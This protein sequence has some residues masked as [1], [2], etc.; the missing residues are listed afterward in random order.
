MSF[1]IVVPEYRVNGVEGRRQLQAVVRVRQQDGFMSKDF[2]VGIYNRN[3]TLCSLYSGKYVDSNRQCQR[4][5]R[6]IEI[7]K[8]ASMYGGRVCK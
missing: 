6:L 7:G 5:F 3:N 1:H 4:P 8:D 2:D